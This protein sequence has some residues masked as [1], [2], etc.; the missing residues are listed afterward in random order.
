MR[1]LFIISILLLTTS[2]VSFAIPAK[3]GQWTTITLVD[4][5]SVRV[6][7][8]GDEH[9]HYFQAADGTAYQMMDDF[10]NQF[11]EKSPSSS[12]SSSRIKYIVVF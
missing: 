2:L 7:V 12:S 10:D 3:P 5:T 4:G 11:R 1:K 6:Q 9:G 8:V